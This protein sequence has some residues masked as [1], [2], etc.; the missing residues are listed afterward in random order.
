MCA[1]SEA[2]CFVLFNDPSLPMLKLFLL[3]GPLFT[4]ST[5]FFIANL[6]KRKVY[7]LH[8]L[9]PYFHLSHLDPEEAR[10]CCHCSCKAIP[11]LMS[12]LSVNTVPVSLRVPR[13]FLN[14]HHS[15]VFHCLWAF[16]HNAQHLLNPC[17]VLE[18]LDIC[19]GPRLPGL[20]YRLLH[21]SQCIFHPS[22]TRIFVQWKCVQV[23]V[24]FQTPQRLFIVQTRQG[25]GLLSWIM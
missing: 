3:A 22:A 18:L 17:N 23:S 5:R 1:S 11:W 4:Q 21:G 15:L 24:L 7:I 6:L 14:P 12:P 10:F 19:H 2:P 20:S 9:F 8:D 25:F 13:F 16:F